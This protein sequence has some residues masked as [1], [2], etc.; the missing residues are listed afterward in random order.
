MGLQTWRTGQAAT[1]SLKNYSRG[2]NI[3]INL[4]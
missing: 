3:D 2:A 1:E 4:P